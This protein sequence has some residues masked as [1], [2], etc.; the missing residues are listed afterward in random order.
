MPRSTKSDLH[1]YTLI[2]N[3]RYVVFNDVFND[4]RTHTRAVLLEEYPE[5]I[6]GTTKDG[7]RRRMRGFGIDPAW[8]VFDLSL[9]SLEHTI[10]VAET[11]DVFIGAGDEVKPLGSGAIMR[12]KGER[13][14]TIQLWVED[15]DKPIDIRKI[16][17][18]HEVI[19]EV[20]R[21]LSV[22]TAQ[23]W[24]AP[25]MPRLT[26]VPVAVARAMVRG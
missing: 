15:D 22:R 8:P 7:T 24:V 14:P 2:T 12:F 11:R 3:L 5:D 23:Y 9:D 6:P 26:H 16:E 19:H 10:E 20:W 4:V 17:G 18:S 25:Y 1:R 21:A 13:G